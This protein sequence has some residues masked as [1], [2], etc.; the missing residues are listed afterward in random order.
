MSDEKTK[1]GSPDRDRIN[2]H[3]RCD[4]VYWRKKFGI[5]PDELLAALEKELKRRL[6]REGREVAASG[7]I[8]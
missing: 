3:E 2:D 4:I 7:A 5:T 8:G 6:S 1:K